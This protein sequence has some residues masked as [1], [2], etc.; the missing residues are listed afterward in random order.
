MLLDVDILEMFILFHILLRHPT[1]PL[2]I[3]SVCFAEFSLFSGTIV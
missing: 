2:Y 3:F 1:I